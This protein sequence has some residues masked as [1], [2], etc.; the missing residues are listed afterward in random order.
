MIA[1]AYNIT[2]E[3]MEPTCAPLM[4]RLYI[5]PVRGCH[6]RVRFLDGALRK[7]LV[8]DVTPIDALIINTQRAPN[9]DADWAAD[10]TLRLVE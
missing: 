1:M 10:L 2:W 8:L 6:V 9:P 3:G 4:A 5:P 7:C